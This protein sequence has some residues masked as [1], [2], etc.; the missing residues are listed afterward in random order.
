MNKRPS[1]F[2]LKQK[3]FLKFSAITFN[4]KQYYASEILL[5]LKKEY[6]EFDYKPSR[7]QVNK[8]LTELVEEGII[9]HHIHSPLS[10]N[11]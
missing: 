8:A 10:Y 6:S 3:Q 9:E 1:T 11:G 2:L 7:T 4:K 5:L